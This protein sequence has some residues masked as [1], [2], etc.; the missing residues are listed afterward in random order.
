MK[1]PPKCLVLATLLTINASAQ[2]PLRIEWSSATI[3]QTITDSDG[4]A[5]NAADYAIELGGFG[6]GFV[7]TGDNIDEWVSNWQVFDAVTTPDDDVGD[8]FVS[9]SGTDARFAGADFLDVD[10]TS[11]SLDGNGTDIF[12]AGLQAYVFIRN[13]DVTGPDSE[14]LLYTSQEGVDW[15]FPAVAGSQLQQP[16]NFSLGEA[17]EFLFGAGNGVVGPGEVGPNAPTDF[18]LRTHTFVPEPS[19]PL[20]L[21]ASALGLACRRRRVAGA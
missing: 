1:T 8:I 3:A 10:Q 19:T 12:S 17:D 16:L 6:N 20:L 21:L 5:I 14:W 18:A 2:S 15:E 7:P 4:N 13:S 9:G 11:L